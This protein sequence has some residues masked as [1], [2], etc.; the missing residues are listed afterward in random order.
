NS[1]AEHGLSLMSTGLGYAG[2]PRGSLAEQ[3]VAQKQPGME[4]QP[5]TAAWRSTNA[6]SAP[7]GKVHVSC[8]R[9]ETRNSHWEEGEE[10]SA[11]PSGLGQKVV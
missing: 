4:T 6:G 7:P 3:A 11:V 1:T 8:S 10:S 2:Q 5:R 9:T